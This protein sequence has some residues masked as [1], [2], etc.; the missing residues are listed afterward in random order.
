[1]GDL[2]LP[3]RA[4]FETWQGLPRADQVNR[5]PDQLILPHPRIQDRGFVLVPMLDVAP[6]WIHPILGLSV[7]QMHAALPDA[8]LADIVETNWD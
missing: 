6:D 1:M 7:R 8:D 2:V 4:V 3:S 5:T